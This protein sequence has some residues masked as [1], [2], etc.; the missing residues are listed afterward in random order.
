MNSEYLK[1][2]EKMEWECQTGIGSNGNDGA[3]YRKENIKVLRT[4]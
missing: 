2:R 3:E 4:S 1:K